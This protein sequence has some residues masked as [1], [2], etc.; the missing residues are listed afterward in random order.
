[1]PRPGT[2][3]HL[4]DLRAHPGDRPALIEGRTGR[5]HTYAQL[6]QAVEDCAARLTAA[7]LRPGDLVAL[8]ADEAAAFIAGY[9]GTL[10][11]GGVV[12]PLDPRAATEPTAQWMITDE[13]LARTG[14]GA[15]KGPAPAA[16]VAAS[17]GTTGASR[18]VV[19][20]HANL[21]ANLEQIHE[22]H[23]L[24]SDDTVLAV[25]PLRHIYGMQMAM[26]HALMTGAALL[27]VP[28]PLD[29]DV[30]LGLAR[31]HRATVAY[32]VPAVIARLAERTGPAAPLPHLRA[33][34]SGGAPLTAPE[35][36]AFTA[37]W[38]V[39][40]LQGYGSTEAGCALFVPDNAPD[41]PPGT[42]GR[43]LPG[44]EVRLAPDGE[45]LV[46]G[47][48]IAAAHLD[49]S[50][51][52]DEH[53]WWHSGDLARIDNGWYAIS[54][55]T[56]DMIKYKGHQVA[57]QR[58]EQ[59]LLAHRAVADAAVVGVPDPLDGELPKA[60]VVLHRPHPLSDLLDHV[61][62]AVPPQQRLRLIE[63][64]E[65]LPRNGMGKLQRT[66]LTD[67]H[68][69]DGRSVVLTG[70]GTGLG[71]VYA[72]ALAERGA[73]LVLIGRRKDALDA[74]AADI[75][76]QGG[77]AITVPA[78]VTDPGAM[79]EAARRAAAEFGG[80]DLLVNNAGI[81]GPHGPVWET[82]DDAW[83]RAMETNLHGT[84]RA[85]RAVLPH[86]IARRRG[87]VVN[88]VSH[89][90]L[91]TWP[92]ASAYSVSKAAVIKFGEN[93]AAETRRHGVTVL[94]YHPGLLD[95]GLTREHRLSPHSGNEWSDRLG[96][97]VRRE[98]ANGRFDSVDRSVHQLLR[99][100]AGTAD[101]LTGTYIAVG[102]DIE[103][104][105]REALR[106][107]EIELDGNWTEG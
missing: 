60:F 23:Q 98:H 66:E 70:A 2:L 102:D 83:W 33:V 79:D 31:E 46:R 51:V 37:R 20:T 9:H 58:L 78:D 54:G 8:A 11:A 76:D 40:V 1:M 91:A 39:P 21:T 22:V 93:L 13:G 62:D 12:Q 55:R 96:D 52:T 95:V 41:A 61:A 48:Q 103:D 73:R 104:R 36:R 3:P 80:V 94:N 90:G 47:P 75:R 69:I 59:L 17:S 6:A 27:T 88:I 100:A 7:G 4:V 49:G 68:R 67:R 99:L 26:N 10:Q 25:T 64:V 32:L 97:W 87:R 28:T 84:V 38:G 15:G 107:K 16:V 85:C 106:A 65:Q 29:L 71:R 57:P 18:H 105:H 101:S 50:P 72:L 35:A 5:V 92:N 77:T 63:A 89:A 86:M 42:V 74:V 44:T 81:A 45:L 24:N 19:L 82:D 30:L 43:P 14:A 34:V 53:G 56:K